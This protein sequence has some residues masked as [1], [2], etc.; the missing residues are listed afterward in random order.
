VVWFY[1]E[2]PGPAADTRVLRHQ[3]MT[4]K[5]VSIS[6]KKIYLFV[7]PLCQMA[8]KLVDVSMDKSPLTDE[9]SVGLGASHARKYA[10]RSACQQ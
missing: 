5:E 3:E 10:F 7:L 4:S 8:S 9:R 6:Y 2:Q 1:V